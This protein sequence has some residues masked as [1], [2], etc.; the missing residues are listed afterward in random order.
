MLTYAIVCDNLK[1]L[2][3]HVSDLNKGIFSMESDIRFL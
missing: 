2:G 1:G 3:F